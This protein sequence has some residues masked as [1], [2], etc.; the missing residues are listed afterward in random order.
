MGTAEHTQDQLEEE[1][2][3]RAARSASVVLAV[4]ASGRTEG[5]EQVVDRKERG[6]EARTAERL[7]TQSVIDVMGSDRKRSR[8][9]LTSP[10]QLSQFRAS[11][12]LPRS[13][14][15]HVASACIAIFCRAATELTARRPRSASRCLLPTVSR[16]NGRSSSVQVDLRPGVQLRAGPIE[17]EPP[18]TENLLQASAG[19]DS[20]QAGHICLTE[21]ERPI[22]ERTSL[23]SSRVPRPTG[24]EKF[25]IV[26]THL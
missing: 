17:Q 16:A 23:H 2:E 22:R 20:R 18:Q 12:S 8:L 14:A 4:C 1:K 21:E 19:Q 7:S 9:N 15:S 25:G 13:H 3:L 11:A 26:T 6:C 5:V 24:T 10:F